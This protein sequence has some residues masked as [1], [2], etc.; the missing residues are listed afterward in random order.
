MDEKGIV[1]KEELISDLL[2]L[3]NF[4]HPE[5]MP[6]IDEDTKKGILCSRQTEEMFRNSY[7]SLPKI[8]RECVKR[9]ERKND[10]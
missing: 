7:G 9:Q 6:M 2:N 1:T 10:L 5:D 8:I 3:Y 4:A